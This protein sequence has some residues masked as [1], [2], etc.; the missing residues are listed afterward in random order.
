MPRFKWNTS[1]GS[2]CAK[3]VMKGVTTPRQ[4]KEN[5]QVQI[6][7]VYP[8]TKLKR[9]SARHRVTRKALSF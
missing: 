1:I 8:H 4:H 3:K 5:R 7:V 2:T 9:R 6:H